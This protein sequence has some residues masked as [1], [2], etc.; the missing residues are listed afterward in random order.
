VTLLSV[1]LQ[2]KSDLDHLVVADVSR[3]HTVTY[4]D[5]A[6]RSVRLVAE[7]TTLIT[8]NKHNGRTSVLSEGFEP[9]ILLIDGPQAHALERTATGTDVTSA[10]SIIVQPIELGTKF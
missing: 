1:A 2:P 4:K 9:A 6:D 10:L 7:T 3:S 5:Q 8:H